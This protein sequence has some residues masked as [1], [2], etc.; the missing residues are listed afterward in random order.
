MNGRRWNADEV[1][2]IPG[3]AIG[4]YAWF[5]K[6][7]RS[8]EIPLDKS[9]LVYIGM[10]KSSFEERNHFLHDDS[11]FSSPRRSLG[12]LLKEAGK[13]PLYAQPRAG[14]NN[15]QAIQNFHFGQGEDSLTK[16]MADNLCYCRVPVKNRVKEIEREV[17]QLLSPPLNLTISKNPHRALVKKARSKCRIEA[18]AL[19]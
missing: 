14:G 17:I 15:R 7:D 13:L 10:T 6:D 8:I 2:D 5:L 1:S 16:W 3:S 12:A 9:R 18:A 4:L 19:L 11:S